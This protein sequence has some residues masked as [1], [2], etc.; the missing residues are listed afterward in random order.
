MP[1]RDDAVHHNYPGDLKLDLARRERDDGRTAG[2]FRPSR[3]CIHPRTIRRHGR[4]DGGN[5]IQHGAFR[6]IR[7]RNGS[8]ARDPALQQ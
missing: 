8:T 1:K 3:V 4:N 2:D 6:A 7:N 5:R